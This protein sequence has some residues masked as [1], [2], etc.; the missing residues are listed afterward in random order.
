MLE[1]N[2][3]NHCI[4]HLLSLSL[5]KKPSVSQC[6][7]SLPLLYHAFSQQSPGLC[8]QFMHLPYVRINLSQT[9]T[10]R[11]KIT[12]VHTKTIR[13]PMSPQTRSLTRTDSRWFAS[14]GGTTM[15]LKPRLSPPHGRNHPATSTA[16][17]Q[18][19]ASQRSSR[20]LKFVKQSL[21]A[22]VSML[23]SRSKSLSWA[24][25]SALPSPN[26]AV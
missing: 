10:I 5:L 19:A 7:S 13:V 3:E 1:F 9:A 12:R 15:L 26:P 24:P 8:Q 22:S 23:A 6:S 16:L 25:R 4:E 14:V 21:R 17:A 11:P 2:S 20:E 18:S